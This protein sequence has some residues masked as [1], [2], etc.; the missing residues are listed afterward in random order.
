MAIINFKYSSNWEY[1]T[2]EDQTGSFVAAVSF[3][4][5]ILKNVV[6]GDRMTIQYRCVSMGLSKGLPFGVSRSQFTD[7]SV[8]FGSVVSN[9]YFGAF[10]FPCRGYILSAGGTLGVLQSDGATSG[11]LW[12]IFYFGLSPFAALRCSGAYRATTPGGGV[13]GGLAGFELEDYTKG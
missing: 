5:I 3:G 13:G 2:S 8:G 11:Q 12:N 4:K 7:P 9:N 1:E 10:D 6:D